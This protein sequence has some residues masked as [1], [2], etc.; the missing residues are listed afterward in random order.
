MRAVVYAR[1]STDLQNP[2]SIEDQIR[3]CKERIS[4]EGWAYQAAY[5]DRAI[6]GAVQL[7]ASYDTRGFLRMLVAAY[8]TL[9]WPK[10]WIASLATWST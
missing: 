8:S 2:S 10:P 7:R 1:Y 4:R 6:T 5:A 3:V 9:S